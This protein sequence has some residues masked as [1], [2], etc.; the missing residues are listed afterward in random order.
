LT[1]PFLRSGDRMLARVLA[2]DAGW[3]IADSPYL[4][5]AT[6]AEWLDHLS[7]A[8]GA[9]ASPAA[10]AGAAPGARS[11]A[12]LSPK[13]RA[14][15]RQQQA[16]ARQRAPDAAIVRHLKYGPSERYWLDYIVN[17]YAGQRR[18]IVYLAGVP[19][20]H[21]T[22]PHH[23]DYVATAQHGVDEVEPSTGS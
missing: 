16:A 18:G 6:D 10:V 13:Q 1:G 9:G 8:S 15:Q 3:F 22:L 12:K 21:D 20:R 7:R 2:F 11:S 19:D 4:L 5:R 14:R 23:A 17:G